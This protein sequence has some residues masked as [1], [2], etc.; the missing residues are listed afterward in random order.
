MYALVTDVA[1]ITNLSSEDGGKLPPISLYVEGNA[2]EN[3]K[4]EILQL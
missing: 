3:L 1:R 4:T 2:C